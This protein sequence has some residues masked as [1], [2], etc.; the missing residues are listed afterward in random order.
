EAMKEQNTGIH[1]DIMAQYYTRRADVISELDSEDDALELYEKALEIYIRSDDLYGQG[2][3]LNNMHA[4]YA[5]HGD[6]VTSLRTME[7]S[8]RINLKLDDKLG[9]AIGYYN[10]AEYYQEINMLDQAREYYDKYM[11]LNDIIKNEIGLGYG[12]FGLGKLHWLDGE[13]EKSR[14][15]FEGALEI[16]E[17]LRIDQMK[18]SCDLMIAQIHVQMGEFDKARKILDLISDDDAMNPTIDLFILYMKGLVQLHHPDSDRESYECAEVLLRQI[19]NSSAD[20]TEVDIALYY[21]ALNTALQY[22]DRKEDMIAALREGSEKLA[23]KLQS[24]QSYSIRNSIMTRREITEFI[25]L[26]RS[27]DMPFPPDGIV[28]TSDR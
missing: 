17:K 12:R 4:I 16:F 26:C 6:Y 23:K 8:I 10:I 28:F 2:T 5:Y 7:E 22:L 19:I 21:S 18:A 25:D 15:Y 11:E 3:V 14:F 13:L 1:D 24:I 20:H 9:L 27:N